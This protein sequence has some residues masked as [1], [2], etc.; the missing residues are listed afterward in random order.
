MRVRNSNF[1]RVILIAFFALSGSG[2]FLSGLNDFQEVHFKNGKVGSEAIQTVVTNNPNAVMRHLRGLKFG[3]LIN[4]KDETQR[5]I[6]LWAAKYNQLDA[7]KN[8]LTIA[9]DED[10]LVSDD[11]LEVSVNYQDL[12][13]GNTPLHE[14]VINKNLQMVQLLLKNK[15]DQ[16]L[17]NNLGN[18]PLHEAVIASNLLIAQQL[19]ND[20]LKEY[21]REFIDV[22]NKLNKTA[23]DL[24]PKGSAL[25]KYLS[26]IINPE[27][28]EEKK[29]EKGKEDVLKLA[30]EEA[31][32][33]KN[34][35]DLGEPGQ[36]KLPHVKKA[37][38][39]L[40]RRR[41]TKKLKELNQEI[42]MRSEQLKAEI[43][44]RD[45]ERQ[46]KRE[47]TVAN[48]KKFKE[49][50]DG[51]V[52]KNGK[53]PLTK[54]KLQALLKQN[55]LEK[56]FANLNLI[57]DSNISVQSFHKEID[58]KIDKLNKKMGIQD[59]EL[60]PPSEAKEYPK[61]VVGAHVVVS[62]SEVVVSA[63]SVKSKPDSQLQGQLK[64]LS[65]SLGVLRS[66][67]NDLRKA[68]GE[69]KGNLHS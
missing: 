31:K 46:I 23:L 68:L 69:L 55:N 45:E 37:Q 65:T 19:I 63:V 18:T 34:K 50:L 26:Q 66:K 15:A 6:V 54:V 53:K 60:N 9:F 29:E 64:K 40:S 4:S 10:D 16:F 51:F 39:P 43:E 47:N 38:G 57:S 52:I 12:A 11:D 59:V 28:V 49:D 25:D 41:P 42:K 24:A 3:M 22:K 32:K 62:E 2:C 17:T 56:Y 8:I 14:A 1:F 67:L 30:E 5:A 27:I 44:K 7:F 61:K 58:V 20:L 21:Q 35:I 33:K 13:T 36:P 48:L